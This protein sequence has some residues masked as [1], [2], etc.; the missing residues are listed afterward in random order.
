LEAA[1]RD[2]PAHWEFVKML[3]EMTNQI[4]RERVKKKSRYDMLLDDDEIAKFLDEEIG[5]TARSPR[6][7]P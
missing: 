6:I 5:P 1:Q 3:F 7:A 2:E 4:E